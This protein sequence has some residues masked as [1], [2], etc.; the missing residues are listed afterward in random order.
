MA[1]VVLQAAGAGLGTLIGGPLGGLLG[2]ALG[3]VAGS[4]I[5]EKLFGGA[6]TVKGPRLSDLRVMASSEGAPI[7]RVWGRMRVAGQV[8]WATQFLESVSTT[9][10]GKGS[11]SPTVTTYSYSVSLAIAL[12]AGEINGIGRIWADG[13]EIAPGDLNLRL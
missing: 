10:G 7:P 12:C 3:A 9:G 2:R 1:T 6:K 4:F 5:D 13:A 11:P 8:I